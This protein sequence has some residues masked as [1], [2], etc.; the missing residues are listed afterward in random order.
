MA[1]NY[2]LEK[3]KAVDLNSFSICRFFNTLALPV[4]LPVDRI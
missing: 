1:I 4:A 3:K 2:G